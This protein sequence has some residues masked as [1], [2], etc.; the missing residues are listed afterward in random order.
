VDIIL[1]ISTSVSDELG[2]VKPGFLVLGTF[3]EKKL[4][5]KINILYAYLL[6]I[7]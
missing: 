4:E 5:M 2:H 3:S 6:F 1:L 7:I